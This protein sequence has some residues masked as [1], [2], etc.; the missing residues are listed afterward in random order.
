LQVLTRKPLH[1]SIDGAKCLKIGG[2]EPWVTR[3]RCAR[4]Q[5]GAGKTLGRNGGASGEAPTFDRLAPDGLEL[6][7]TLGTRL[8]KD[9]IIV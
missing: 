7:E 9:K 3:R 8:R 4:D 2:I 1:S 6:A 5:G